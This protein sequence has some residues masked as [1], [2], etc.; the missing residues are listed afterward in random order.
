M[1]GWR[2]SVVGAVALVAGLIVAPRFVGPVE[3]SEA[4]VVGSSAWAEEVV[5]LSLCEAMDNPLVP[6]FVAAAADREACRVGGSVSLSLCEAIVRA[7]GSL[8]ETVN[9]PSDPALVDACAVVWSARPLN[10][11]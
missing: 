6:R 1:T 5:G 2:T 7:D 8:R 10:A 4:S 3:V 11:R 9:G